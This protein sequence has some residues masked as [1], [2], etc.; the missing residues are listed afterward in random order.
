MKK[1]N[2]KEMMVALKKK[3]VAVAGTTNEFYSEDNEINGIWVSGE[4][5]T[6]KKTDLPF[7]DYYGPESLYFF[8]TLQTLED[9]IAKHGWYS[10]CNDPGTF[11]LW[12]S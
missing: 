3:G 10:E 6:C 4:E 1:Y 2:L 8:G 12:E 7:F 11:M 5:G 9:F